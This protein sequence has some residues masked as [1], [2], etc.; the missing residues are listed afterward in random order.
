MQ[1]KQ[2]DVLQA[3]LTPRLPNGGV[4]FLVSDSDCPPR[5]RVT[6]RLMQQSIK[7]A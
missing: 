1:R 6:R 5:G 2:R 4:R 3:H 7:L